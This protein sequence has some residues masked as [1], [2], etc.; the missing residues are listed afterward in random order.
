MDDNITVSDFLVIEFYY[1][2]SMFLNVHPTKL[3]QY[4]HKY[5]DRTMQAAHYV[6]E[7]K[8]SIQ[9]KRHIYDIKNITSTTV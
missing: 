2:L 9:C 8:C 4:K 7:H 3:A 6:L 1:E 5:P